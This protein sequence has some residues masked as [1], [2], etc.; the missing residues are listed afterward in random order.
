MEHDRLAIRGA[1]SD[2]ISPEILD[3]MGAEHA[4]FTALTVPNRG[5]APMLDEPPAVQAIDA[6]LKKLET[7]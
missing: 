4:D 7:M 1:L 5:H 6:F 3:A 2:I